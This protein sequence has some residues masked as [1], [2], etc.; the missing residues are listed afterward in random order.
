MDEVTD[1]R[2]TVVIHRRAKGDVAMIALD[3][4]EGIMETLHLFR[5]PANRSRLEQAIEDSR[6]EAPMELDT[7][8][9]EVGLE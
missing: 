2:E 3:E 9:K 1:N 6:N 7:L 8:R 5:S 4:L